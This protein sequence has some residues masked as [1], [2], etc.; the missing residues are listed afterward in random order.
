MYSLCARVVKVTVKVYHCANGDGPF[1]EQIAFGSY[2]VHQFKFDEDCYGDGNG[3]GT[4]KR[5][6][7]VRVSEVYSAI[8]KAAGRAIPSFAWYNSCGTEKIP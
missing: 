2:S 4:C 7:T 5:T 6:F 1:D 3:D 8:H